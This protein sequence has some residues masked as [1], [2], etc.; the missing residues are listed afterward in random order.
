MPRRAHNG[1]VLLA[2]VGLLGCQGEAS[3]QGGD[4]LQ[5]AD[6]LAS[7]GDGLNTP[8]NLGSIL[9]T[10][11]N[12]NLRTGPATTY[13]VRTVLPKGAQV[14]TVN[15]T[16]PQGDWYNVKYNGLV[17]WVH[18]GYVVLVQEG[19]APTPTPPP[20]PVSSRAAAVARAQSGV[21]YSYWWGHGRWIPNASASSAGSCTGNC[22]SCTHGGS[23]GADCSGY[24]AK[25]WQI[26]STN[27]DP[28]VDSHPYSTATFVGTSSLW[29]TVD[30]GAVQL[31]DALVYNDGTSGHVFLYESGDGWGSMW[32]YEAKGCAYGIVH[33]LRTASGAYKGI[34]HY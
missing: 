1:L 8:L 6:E 18:G 10:T 12:L 29:R 23:Y 30:R 14:T 24:V 21:G 3:L 17:G 33:D 5:G 20:P 11:A 26:P 22:P 2:V 9:K 15:Q 27:T 7:T 19:P 13:P 25:L 4:A 16:T 31:G 32:A 34:A 28:T